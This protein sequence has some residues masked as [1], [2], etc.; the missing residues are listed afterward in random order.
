MW[1]NN[2]KVFVLEWVNYKSS[3]DL[4]KDIENLK[5]D[6]GYEPKVDLRK[7][8]EKTIEWYKKEKWLK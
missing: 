8:V 1:V 3:E 7:G 5:Q 6:L 2:A 4:D